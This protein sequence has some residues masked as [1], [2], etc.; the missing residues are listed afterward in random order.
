MQKGEIRLNFASIKSKVPFLITCF[1]QVERATHMFY[2]MSMTC[3][4]LWMGRPVVCSSSSVKSNLKKICMN[5]T[6]KWK[7]L[8]KT[9][10]SCK[11]HGKILFYTSCTSYGKQNGVEIKKIVFKQSL[12]TIN[13]RLSNIHPLHL[14]GVMVNLT[15]IFQKFKMAK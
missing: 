12:P 6:A 14:G 9:R 5:F 3:P 13:N 8:N 1:L 2:Q 4:F 15:H 11:S 7:Y 10:N